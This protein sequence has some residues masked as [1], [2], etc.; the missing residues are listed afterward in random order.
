MI[1]LRALH[2]KNLSPIV[3]FHEEEPTQQI[4]SQLSSFPQIY[5]VRGSALKDSDLDKIN[6]EDAKQVVILSPLISKKPGVDKTPT[7][8]MSEQEESM[9]KEDNMDD[10]TVK[11]KKEKDEENLMDAQ[12]IFKYNIIKRRHKSVKIITELYSHQNLAYLDDPNIYTVMNEYGYDQTPIFAAGEVYSSSLMDSL[13][14]QACYNSAL[15]TV[16]RQLVIGET[17]KSFQKKNIV[18]FGKEFTKIKSS[19]L[20]HVHVPEYLIG[21][22]FNKLYKEFALE[23]YM[24][25]LGLYRKDTIIKDKKRADS[26]Y[27]ENDVKN[28]QEININY[29]VT[30]PSPDTILRESDIVFVLAYE[31]PAD[32]KITEKD[33][34][35]ILEEKATSKSKSVTWSNQITSINEQRKVDAIKVMTKRTTIDFEKSLDGL[36]RR[37]IAL[38]K[39]LNKNSTYMVK[40]VIGYIT[41]TIDEVAEQ[42]KQ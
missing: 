9:L 40:R 31:D 23:K 24:I 3:I 28:K 22:K 38:H 6:L 1:P 2:L 11:E 20:Y 12:T 33:Q 27:D 26:L 18:T 35:D 29:V 25:P 8:R 34:M 4:W 37:I 14:C 15:I 39:K 19:N 13:V 32:I 36:R 41:E 42:E 5:F 17:R 21:S 30:N 10:D 7:Q 16:L